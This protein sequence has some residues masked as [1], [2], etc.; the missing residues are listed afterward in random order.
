M[1]EPCRLFPWE[2][3]RYGPNTT[4]IISITSICLPVY[5]S[6]CLSTYLSIYLSIY[7]SIYLPAKMAFTGCFLPVWLEF[8]GAAAA[9]FLKYGGFPVGLRPRS[10]FTL[11]SCSGHVPIDNLG[12][13]SLGDREP[14]PLCNWKL[15]LKV[16]DRYSTTYHESRVKIH[17]WASW[18]ISRLA[19]W[20]RLLD[21]D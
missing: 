14:R 12:K 7:P 4:P 8:I 16:T 5:L 17:A 19:S 1:L 13:W 18:F 21:H 20:T 10:I 11:R 9:S 3:A 2:R 6:V 15:T